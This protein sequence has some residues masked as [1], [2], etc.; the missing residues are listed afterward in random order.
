L[1]NELVFKKIG[2]HGLKRTHYLV[3]RKPDKNKKYI[4]D[5]LLNFEENFQKSE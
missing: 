3:V 1:S 5:F 2:K 4:N